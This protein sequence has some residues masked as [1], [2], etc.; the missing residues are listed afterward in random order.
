MPI[1]E[2]PEVQG[3]RGSEASSELHLRSTLTTG[4]NLASRAVQCVF[5]R[6]AQDVVHL[7]E[8]LQV[9]ADRGTSVKDLMALGDCLCRT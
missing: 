5:A 1:S 3:H 2:V 6:P 9:V 4:G 7:I 8:V